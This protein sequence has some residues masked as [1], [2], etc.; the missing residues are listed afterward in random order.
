MKHRRPKRPTREQKKKIT[1][2]GYRPE[3]FL[4]QNEDN[5]SMTLVHK[6]TEVRKVILL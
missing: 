5:I 6:K 2:A 3:E 1:A 4:V